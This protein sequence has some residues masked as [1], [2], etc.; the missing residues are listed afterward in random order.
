MNLGIISEVDS[1]DSSA[2]VA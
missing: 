1:S 2:R